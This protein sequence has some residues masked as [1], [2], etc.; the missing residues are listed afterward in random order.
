MNRVWPHYAGSY[1]HALR[2]RLLPLLCECWWMRCS[3]SSQELHS[4]QV[5]NFKAE[6]FSAVCACLGIKKTHTTPLH[7]QSK[8]LVSLDHFT[9]CR[10]HWRTP[11]RLG[12]T[13]PWISCL[14]HH[15]NWIYRLS[16]ERTI[17]C[18][19]HT[20]FIVWGGTLMLGSRFG[21]TPWCGRKDCCLS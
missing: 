17:S 12:C 9:A 10:T 14:E 2:G 21:F 20:M 19:T 4:Q 7:H 6:E 18:A 11:K 15:C 3:V 13:L 1:H 16:L 8:G 5:H